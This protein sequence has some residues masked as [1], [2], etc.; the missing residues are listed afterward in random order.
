VNAANLLADLEEFIDDHRPHGPLTA[1]SSTVWEP[2]L[3][4]ENARMGTPHLRKCHL[5]VSRP[6][7]SKF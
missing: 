5:A 1:S 3:K 2:I 7:H 6:P 4:V